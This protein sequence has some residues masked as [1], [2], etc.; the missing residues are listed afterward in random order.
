[1]RP[2]PLL[3]VLMLLVFSSCYRETIQFEGDPPD[4]Y[5]Q[6]VRIDTVTPQFS[7]VL[8]DSFPTGGASAFLV[9]G[10]T[11]PYFGKITTRAFLQI[12]K[13]EGEI[14]LAENAVYDSLVL[15]IKLNK[16]YYGDSTQ[17]VTI[18]VHELNE[19]LVLGYNDELYNN[20]NFSVKSPTLGSKQL[21]IYPNINDSIIV[22]L[23]Q[24]KGL[25]LFGKIKSK[26]DEMASAENFLGYFK[27]IR[28]AMPD[29]ANGV[30]YGLAGAAGSIK[31][32]LH[33]HTTIPYPEAQFIDFSSLANDLS[34]KQILVDRNG[35]LPDPV[36]A[37]KHELP[38]TETNHIG[39]TQ[40]ATGALLKV[41]FPGLRNI[42]STDQ[43]VN[44]LHAELI[45]RP[46]NQ[47]FSIY[48]LP[49]TLLLAQT[50]ESNFIGNLLADSTGQASV[51]GSP[52]I[53]K[54]YGVNNYYRFNIT[55]H[56]NTLLHTPGSA[57][58]GFFILDTSPGQAT[59]LDRAVFG[60]ASHAENKV[61]LVLSIV[62]V[63]LE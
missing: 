9:G 6:V 50:D 56:V 41:V 45:L 7:T 60:D 24:A 17:P 53:D 52:V 33:Y 54:L 1:M 18:D 62:T 35:L 51:S 32:R 44:L 2:G 58:K 14:T 63:N 57:G 30:A 12:N 29:A 11:D 16:Y 15:I 47:S 25:E 48:T 22:R 13:P 46:V 31:M 5:T 59:K 49:P 38:S 28:I 4:S 27:G 8:I 37:G 21:R 23:D 55:N 34:F 3:Y 19:T 26:A 36:T 42:L 43:P 39:F 61:Q 10:Y 40:P 20:S